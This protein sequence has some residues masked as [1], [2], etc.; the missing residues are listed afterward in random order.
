MRGVQRRF[1]ETAMRRAV[2]RKRDGG[3]LSREE[4]REIVAGYLAGSVD[5]AQVAA[6]LMASLWRGLSSAEAAALTEAMVASGERLHFPDGMFVVDKHSS[7]GVSDIVSLVAVPLAAAAGARVAK[8]SGRALGH[9]GGTI[10]KLDAIP[11]VRTNL[12]L[13][14]FVDQVARIGCAI[15]AQT[16][17]LA[18]A[19]KR[20]YVLRDRT[21]TVPCIGLIAASILSKKIA[22]GANAYVFDVKC[23]T[24][25]FMHSLADAQALARELVAVAAHFEHPA[26]ALVTDMNEP[27]GRSIG[28][29]IEVIEARDFLR[30]PARDARVREAALRI[31]GE[32]LA[33]ARVASPE[34]SATNVLESGAAYEKFVAMIEAQGSSRSALEAMHLPDTLVES[35]APRAG[36]VCAVDAVALGNLARDWSASESTGGIVVAVRIGDRVE[37]DGVLAR[38]YGGAADATAL[39]PAF[40]IGEEQPPPRPLVYA[41]F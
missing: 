38:G 33:L 7:G 32:M 4:W 15:A 13:G 19:D 14:E 29:G 22:G 5:E 10:D 18:P 6:L 16:E 3:E 25:A 36:Y 24:G 12:T 23:G 8:L 2:E 40:T 1:D 39:L 11:G 27:L 41:A 31:A 34:V 21:A 37:R 30:G 20:I 28:T 9:T 26:R 35:R 17:Q